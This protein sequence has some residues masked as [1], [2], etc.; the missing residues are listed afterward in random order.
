[1]EEVL[2]PI[3]NAVII[4]LVGFFVGWIMRKASPLIQP[5]KDWLHANTTDK[6]RQSLQRIAAE[7][8]ALFEATLGSRQG[9]E[10]LRLAKDYVNRGLGAVGSDLSDTDIRA[11]I[12]KALAEY[13]AQQ[14]LRE[15]AKDAN[16]QAKP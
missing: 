12:E 9:Q 8:V 15:V 14:A 2:Q 13:K 5:A 6:Q 4:A 7:A 3:S 1:M 11:A 10:K 16:H